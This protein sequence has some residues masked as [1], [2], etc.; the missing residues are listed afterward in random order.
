MSFASFFKRKHKEKEDNNLAVIGIPT[1]VK[2]GIHVTINSEGIL[3]GLPSAWMKQIDSQITKD[4]QKENPLVVKQVLQYYNYSNKKGN[5][6]GQ[7]YKHIVTE[8][9]IDEESKQIDMYMHSRDAHTSKD[10]ILSET[11]ESSIADKKNENCNRY[12]ISIV[13]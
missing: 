4:E 3:T 1:N 6:D 12:C 5:Q 10:S 11:D 8:E 13:F 7:V 9:D 2:H